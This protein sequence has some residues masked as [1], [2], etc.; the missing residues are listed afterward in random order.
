MTDEL[1]DAILHELKAIRMALED[2][3]P[4]HLLTAQEVA[5]R[6]G[7]GRNWVYAHADELGVVQLPS[8]TG[9][10]PRL[11][12]N[13]SA[14]DDYWQEGNESGVRPTRKQQMPVAELPLLPIRGHHEGS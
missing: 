12:F 10:K 5:D 1:A 6:L 14:V 13:P 3:P 8:K 4:Q 7:V 9:R 11:R 2:R